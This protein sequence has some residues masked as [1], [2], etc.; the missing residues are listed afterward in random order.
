MISRREL[1]VGVTGAC[2]LAQE[3]R[4]GTIPDVAPFQE[5]L[6]FSRKD[7]VT[8]ARPFAMTQVRLLD[9]PFK[10]AEDWNRGYMR[11][12]NA[13][14]LLHNFRVNARLPSSAEPFG[15]WEE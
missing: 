7:A 4:R 2:A 12:L 1:L 8:R 6:T 9:G 13:D 14:R 15:G 3:Q 5:P 11:R 10:D